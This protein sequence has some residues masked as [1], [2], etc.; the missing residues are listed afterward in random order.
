M[1]EDKDCGECQ[2]HRLMAYEVDLLK[3][4]EAKHTQELAELHRL[5]YEV[6]FSVEKSTDAL[7]MR[8]DAL[9]ATIQGLLEEKRNTR[10]TLINPAAVAILSILASAV[11]GFFAGKM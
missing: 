7:N 1:G 11:A 2:N 10:N 6:R 9:N 8:I 4:S 5:M 3:K